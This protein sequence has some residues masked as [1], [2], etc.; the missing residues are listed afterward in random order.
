MLRAS[1][2]AE[3]AGV[4]SVSLI[5]PGFERQAL[6][7]GRGLGFDGMKLAVLD[8]H[9]DSLSHDELIAG[10]LANTVP[11]ILAGLT[12][13]LDDDS[14]V[15]VDEPQALD[16]V[17]S[18]TIDEIIDLFHDRGWSDGLPIVPPTRERVEEFL[19]VT[20]HDPWRV[21]GVAKPG[22]REVTVWSVAVNGVMAGCKPEYL[23]VLLTAA[24]IL[25]GSQYGVEHSGNTTGSDAL[26]VLDGPAITELG[27]NFGPGSHRE[28]H[29][30]N[31]ATGRWLRLFLR[32]VCGFTGDEHDKATYGN[33]AKPVLAEDM[34]ALADIGWAPLSGEFGFGAEES[35]L[36]IARINST[37]MIGSVY[38]ATPEAVV[39][40]LADGLCRVTGWDLTH[41]YGLGGGHYRPLLIISPMIA[42]VFGKA[43]WSKQQLKDALF[44]AARIPAWKFEALIGEWSNL[45]AGRPKLYDLAAEGLVPP[46]FGESADPERLVPIVTEASKFLIA[47]AGD[48]NRANALAMSNDGLHGMWTTRFVDTSPSQDLAC[49]VDGEACAT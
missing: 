2:A 11:Q 9:P 46:V 16:V 47:V 19:A 30:A 41:V 49:L 36:T 13:A 32:N 3:R 12:A 5:T 23:P 35:A 25:C 48:R 7:T 45:T 18:G 43:G 8:A 21:I 22:G 44:A 6:A 20:G 31:T 33:P 40:Y 34:E 24:E 14:A 42:R 37:I 29:R 38:G 39:P 27:F 10:F 26:M 15:A 1:V 17:A 4:P 28:G